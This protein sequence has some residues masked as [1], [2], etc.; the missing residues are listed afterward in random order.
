MLNLDRKSTALLIKKPTSKPPLP[1]TKFPFFLR[2][3]SNLRSRNNKS[4]H[5]SNNI[6]YIS[7][8]SNSSIIPANQQ[9]NDNSLE[10]TNYLNVAK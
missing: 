7:T 9:K 3:Q 6:S 2:I 10:K 4:L 1:N 5:D 8:N